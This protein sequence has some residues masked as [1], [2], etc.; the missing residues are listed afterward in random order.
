MGDWGYMKPTISIVQSQPIQHLLVEIRGHIYDAKG[1]QT[2]ANNHTL[3]ASKKMLWLRKRIEDGEEGNVTW[4]EWF[5]NQPEDSICSRKYAEKLLKIAGAEDPEA[6]S[7]RQ[8]A[9]NR[10]SKAKA[11]APSPSEGRG[12]E[13]DEDNPDNSDDA[14]IVEVAY[15]KVYSLL[16][17]M[18]EQQVQIFLDLITFYREKRGSAR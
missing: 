11:K 5:E 9:A 1:L 8:K 2:R 14:E 12:G 4:W 10:N 3:E 18:S 17:E 15:K 16:E 13:D 6:E 7:E